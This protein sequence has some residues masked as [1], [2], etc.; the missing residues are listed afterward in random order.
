MRVETAHGSALLTGDIGHYVERALLREE[1][2]SLRNDVVVIP[3]HGS[4]GSSDPDFVAATGAR[5]A[6]VSSG[7]GNRF[8]HPRRGVVQRWCEAGAETVDTSRSGALRVW[9]GRDGMALD[10]RRRSRSRLWDGARRRHGA[11][12][13]CYAQETQRP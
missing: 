12:G 4:A 3:H 1:A 9:L 8:G 10:E 13:L 11:A 2:A 7:A 6:V 5:L